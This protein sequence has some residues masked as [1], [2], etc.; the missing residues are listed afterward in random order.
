MLSCVCFCARTTRRA[1]PIT[2]RKQPPYRPRTPP[3]HGRHEHG[4]TVDELIMKTKHRDVR[5]DTH[6]RRHRRICMYVRRKKKTVIFLS[7]DI[8]MLVTND[9][10]QVEVVTNNHCRMSSKERP[11]MLK[12]I[13]YSYREKSSTRSQVEITSK[14]GG[15]RS[16]R[17]DSVR[18]VPLGRSGVSFL[19]RTVV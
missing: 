13:S 16:F 2:T 14:G 17:A 9:E 6:K 5:E 1:F 10:N 4:L 12:N 8:Y 3:P 15:I 11:P 7:W 19:V 18:R